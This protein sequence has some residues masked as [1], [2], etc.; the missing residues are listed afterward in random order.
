M[1]LQKQK[2]RLSIL[3]AAL[4]TALFLLPVP[5]LAASMTRADMVITG[6]SCAA[7]LIRIEKKLKAQPGVLKALVSIYKPYSAIIVYD[8]SRTSLAALNKIISKE[9]AVA[10]RVVEEKLTDLPALLVPKYK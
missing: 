10:A 8:P 2:Q 3:V 6:S 5:A 7:C 9:N 1:S 4:Q